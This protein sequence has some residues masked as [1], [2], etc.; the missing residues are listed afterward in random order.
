MEKGRNQ[1][2]KAGNVEHSQG[3]SSEQ[4][5]GRDANRAVLG[6]YPS[7]GAESDHDDAKSPFCSSLSLSSVSIHY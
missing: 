6:P 2:G 7:T 5:G 1:W 4:P 3:G